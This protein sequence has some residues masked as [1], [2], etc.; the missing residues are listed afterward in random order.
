MDWILYVIIGILIVLFI[1]VK[2][3]S[4]KD[5]PQ[6]ENVTLPYKKRDDFILGRN[7]PVSMDI[8]LRIYKLLQCD[9]GDIMEVIVTNSCKFKFSKELYPKEVMIKAAYHFINDCYVFLDCN[10]EKYSVEIMLKQD[11]NLDLNGIENKFKNELL[12]QVV[13]LQVYRQTHMIR[14]L[15]MARAMSSTMIQKNNSEYETAPDTTED[16][17]DILTDWFEKYE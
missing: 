1:V 9:I 16:L 3:P 15:L 6:N 13:R 17:D 2:K 5:V 8:M 4:S 11:S 7:E 12:S 14:E 10:S